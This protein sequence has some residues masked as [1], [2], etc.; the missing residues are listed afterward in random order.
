AELGVA[1]GE[2]AQR[3]GPVGAG[4]RIGLRRAPEHAYQRFVDVDDRGPV[5]RAE[6]QVPPRGVR[7]TELVDQPDAAPG[8]VGREGVLTRAEPGRVQ[9]D[10]AL[11]EFLDDEVAQAGEAWGASTTAITRRPTR[12]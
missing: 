9:P 7:R 2:P 10:P 12:V 6:Q 8:R 5:C 1:C 4:L 11:R 3:P